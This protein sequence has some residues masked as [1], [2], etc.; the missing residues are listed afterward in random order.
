MNKRNS[1]AD[2]SRLSHDNV[3]LEPTLLTAFFSSK[4]HHPTRK[5]NLG[6]VSHFGDPNLSIEG[7]ALDKS[8]GVVRGF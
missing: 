2:H 4:I 5:E 1:K 7:A 3:V 8:P 6:T